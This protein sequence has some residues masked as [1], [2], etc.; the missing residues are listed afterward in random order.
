MDSQQQCKAKQL[1]KPSKTD[2]RHHPVHSQDETGESHREGKK[3]KKEMKKFVSVSRTVGKGSVCPS[4]CVCLSVSLFRVSPLP[5]TAFS[6]GHH[7]V[8]PHSP[9]PS[10]L[11]NHSFI[12][13]FIHF[14][15]LTFLLIN[16]VDLLRSRDSFLAGWFHAFLLLL[17]FLL[18]HPPRNHIE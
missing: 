14:L 4:S 6:F 13:S 3:K 5:F 15:A 7:F 2:P 1:A 11:F 18:C 12:H 17:S 8:H 10:P 9:S 16:S